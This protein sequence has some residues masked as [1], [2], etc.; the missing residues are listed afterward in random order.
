MMRSCGQEYQRKRAFQLQQRIAQRARQRALGRV[1]HQVQD[2]FGVARCLEDG[3]APLQ[4]GA[5]FRRV[6]DVAV[7]RHRH[8]ALVAGHRKRLRVQQHRI[9]GRGIARV[10]DGQ[11]AR[12]RGQHRGW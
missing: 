9:A 12:Q 2:H 1:R 3:P 10:A 6:G 11:L 8:A 5:Q 7:V 4:V